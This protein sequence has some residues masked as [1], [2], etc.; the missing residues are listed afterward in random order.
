MCGAAAP[1]AAADAYTP[2]AVVTASGFY[3]RGDGGW[4]WLSTD[5]DDN[6]VGVLGGGVGYQFNDNLR[7]DIRGDW[8]GI[9]NDDTSFT[10][11]L[12][13]VYFDIP[14]E[15]IMTPY[16]GAGLGYGWAEYRGQG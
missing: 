13:N 8:A 3:L 9:G 5:E 6:S 2:E 15:T 16:L 11:V 10:T 14:T 1:A 4:S 7:T 12:G